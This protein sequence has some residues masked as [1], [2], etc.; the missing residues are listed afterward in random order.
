MYNAKIV[1]VDDELSS[2]E[3]LLSYLKPLVGSQNIMGTASNVDE[4]YELILKTNPQIVFL[5][6]NLTHESGFDL[7]NKF[8][9]PEFEVV[10]IT[11]YNEFAVKAFKYNA[12]DYLLK[13]IDKEELTE[14]IRKAL[15]KW[16]LVN[17]PPNRYTNLFPHDRELK[18]PF[19]RLCISTKESLL[20]IDFEDLV[21]C[22]SD[23]NY[24]WFILASGEKVLSSKTL[25]EYDEI[26]SEQNFVR[27]HKSHL[28]NLK[29]I[30]SLSK[31]DGGSVVLKDN[32]SIPVS[33]S[34]KMLL[35]HVLKGR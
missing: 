26:L 9:N 20:F 16:E 3:N 12:I 29:Y 10:F 6:I 1:I 14:A 35:L 8:N 24:T 19:S 31:A 23:I 25:K 5:D 13:P 34:H 7:L 4:A 27:V 30:K 21:R 33:K 22:E 17:K 2:R 11:A 28:V 15:T 32:S 18:K